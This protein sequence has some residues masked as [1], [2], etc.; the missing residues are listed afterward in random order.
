MSEQKGFLA[1]AKLGIVLALYAAAAC[2][3]LAFVYAGTFEK[4]EEN[5]RALMNEALLALFPGA[6]FEPVS[7]VRILDADSRVTIDGDENDPF[8]TGVYAARRNGVI[9]GLAIKTSRGGFGGPI[10]LLVGVS[11]NG[12]IMGIR[13]LDHSETPGLGKNAEKPR[14]YGQ[15]DNKPV[16][17]PFV[18]NNDVDAITASTI[19]STAISISVK[20]AG[21]AA[22]AWIRANGGL[23]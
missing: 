23:Q 10:T 4:I 12:K 22:L 20:A 3:G 9:E 21:E 14:F 1:M 17:D 13:I 2:V 7:G 8:N 18:V 11:V 19:T 6:E 5:Q 16:S 15:F